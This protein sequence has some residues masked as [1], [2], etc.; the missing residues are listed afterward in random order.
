MQNVDDIISYINAF[1]DLAALQWCSAG[2]LH[3][4]VYPY[5]FCCFSMLTT[6][7]VLEKP[8]FWADSV[9][10]LEVPLL[11]LFEVDD[12]PDCVE[13]LPDEV[14]NESDGIL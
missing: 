6:L 3:C 12:A 11:R 9:L 1:C 7:S 14:S 13:I 4:S 2:R 10:G 8:Y 5:T